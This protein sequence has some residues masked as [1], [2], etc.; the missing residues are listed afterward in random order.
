MKRVN[1][2]FSPH[3]DDAILSLGGFFA[4]EQGDLV[5]V[6]IC[7]GKPEVP[8]N[9]LWDISSGF[10]DSTEAVDIRTQEDREALSS[11][12]N[13]SIIN[14]N[15]LDSQYIS[16]SDKLF[17]YKKLRK[18]ILIDMQKIVATYEG[19]DIHI[20]GPSVRFHYDHRIVNDIVLYLCKTNRNKTI[21]FYLYQDMPY[22]YY[23]NK[24]QRIIPYEWFI[25]AHCFLHGVRIRREAVELTSDDLRKKMDA[26][27]KYASQVHALGPHTLDIL[28][29]YAKDQAQRLNLS[30][31]AAEVI[32]KIV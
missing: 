26:F 11:Y 27:G 21:S 25:A 17:T 5:I 15:Y 9:T 8:Q 7:G 2:V 22:S 18:E 32:Y 29:K 14:L 23:L 24:I 12:K 16:S 3:F 19:N 30:S 13:T 10:H 31:Y 1:I 28:Q 6:N 4:H 20:Y